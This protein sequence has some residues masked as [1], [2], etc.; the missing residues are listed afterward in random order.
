MN[1]KQFRK[2]G[3]SEVLCAKKGEALGTDNVELHAPP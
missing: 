2:L 1:G 3:S